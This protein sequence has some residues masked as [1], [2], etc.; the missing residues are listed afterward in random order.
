M[1]LKDDTKKVLLDTISKLCTPKKGIL[2]A[3]E[4]ISTIGKRFE[5]INV[6]NTR[7]KR[8]EWRQLLFTTPDIEK[9]ISG[10]IVHEET[11]FDN[12]YN[13]KLA[14]DVPLIAPLLE[15]NIVIGIKLDQGLIE[16]GLD[17]DE[18]WTKGLD[19]LPERAAKAFDAGARFSKWRCVYEIL[20][21]KCIDKNSYVKPSNFMIRE[22]ARVLALYAKISQHAG[23]VPIIE[24]E[25]LMSGCHGLLEA[26]YIQSQI[27]GTLF[28]ELKAYNVWL[29]GVILKTNFVLPSK[30][31]LETHPT[32]SGKDF[33]DFSG[34]DKET[35]D[36]CN[37]TLDA[38]SAY[39]PQQ[40]PAIFFLS[41]GL[42]EK[43]ATNLLKK[44]NDL[45]AERTISKKSQV[46]QYLSFSYGRALQ[47]SALS[48][49]AGKFENLVT[50]QQ[51]FLERC[52]ENSETIRKE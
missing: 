47:T 20:I 4:S 25:L 12:V 27:L 30:T 13:I 17:Y 32:H 28:S 26:S 50:A 33:T 39:V 15:K 43:S 34:F 29:P 16:L 2:A 31:Y 5:T 51:T 36:V 45:K 23:L 7:A 11:L 38:V 40:V 44:L 3:D 22:N 46:L 6:T 42:T 41:G 21:E 49:W 24:P 35:Y 19:S 52:K 8:K 48:V 18:K 14:K 9:Y 1:S 10:A 37:A